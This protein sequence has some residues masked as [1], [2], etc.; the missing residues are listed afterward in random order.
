MSA[1]EHIFLSEKK[2]RI[3][4]ENGIPWAEGYALLSPYLTKGERDK[5]KALESKYYV[6]GQ[7]KFLK[8]Y[9]SWRNVEIENLHLINAI[10]IVILVEET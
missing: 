3:P 7:K 8:L 1:A 2:N 6:T 5:G 10:Q 4:K 9:G